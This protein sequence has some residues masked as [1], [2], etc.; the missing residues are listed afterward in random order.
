[1]TA[2]PRPKSW[3]LPA[4]ITATVLLGDLVGLLST[5][6]VYWDL[7]RSNP[8]GYIAGLLPLILLDLCVALGLGQWVGQRTGSLHLVPPF[9]SLCALGA[10]V[11]ATPFGINA[12]WSISGIHARSAGIVYGIRL[13][14]FAEDVVWFALVIAIFVALL[15][16]HSAAPAE[17]AA[18]DYRGQ[19]LI[20]YALLTW[21][22]LSFVGS[23]I[24]LTAALEPFSR[25]A[26]VV[27]ALWRTAPPFAEAILYAG[28]LIYVLPIAL[29]ARAALRSPMASPRPRRLFLVN[30][31]VLALCLGVFIIVVVA[32]VLAAL[33]IDRGY[34]P[35][36]GSAVLILLAWGTLA[37]G[38]S[39][40]AGRMFL[41][42]DPRAG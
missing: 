37:Y 18:I 3:S 33:A 5:S 6:A 26:K 12:L 35:G 32:L 11:A 1:M 29:G 39:W 15:K 28:L 42:P 25:L 34:S 36:I 2:E 8:T 22:W 30:L 23:F 16:R 41:Q 10:L 31:M 19:S 14:R 21:F 4:R 27:N 38:I 9:W 17:R 24:L 20:L 13:A 40:G 7:I